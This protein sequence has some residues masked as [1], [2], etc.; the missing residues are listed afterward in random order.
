MSYRVFSIPRKVRVRED[1]DFPGPVVIDGI[2]V[3]DV[4]CMSLIVGEG[5]IVDGTI[6]ADTVTILGEV[7]G[8]IFATRLTLKQSSAV[9]GNI[10]HTHLSLENGCLF[11]GRS[12]RHVDPLQLT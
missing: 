3:G 8:E 12:R 9:A 5:G 4:R 7:T 10:F 6:K 1:I 11:E 2:V